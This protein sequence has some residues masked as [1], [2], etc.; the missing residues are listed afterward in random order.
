MF[1]QTYQ[2]TICIW[3]SQYGYVVILL[4]FLSRPTHVHW[5]LCVQ[6]FWDFW[7]KNGESYDPSFQG[8]HNYF[9]RCINKSGPSTCVLLIYQTTERSLAHTRLFFFIVVSLV[10]ITMHKFI[11]FTFSVWPV[12]L[13]VISTVVMLILIHVLR[14]PV[15]FTSAGNIIIMTPLSW[16]GRREQETSIMIGSCTTWYN[17]AQKIVLFN[18]E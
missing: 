18:L 17:K 9:H 4:S 7:Y 5:V 8:A 12:S 13:A 11:T 2:K 6:N 1:K 10:I 15:I 14:I 3:L 16:K